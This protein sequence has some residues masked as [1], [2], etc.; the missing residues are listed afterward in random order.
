[1]TNY[2]QT[3]CVIARS[4][5]TWRSPFVQEIEFNHGGTEIASPSARDDDK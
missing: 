5:A 4:E 1:L 3:R 2:N